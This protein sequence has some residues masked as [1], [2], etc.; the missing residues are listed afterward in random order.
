LSQG[1]ALGPELWNIFFDD[2][3]GIKLP[4]NSELQVFCDDTRVI[5][6]GDD[7]EQIGNIANKVL[8]KL[9]NW[10]KNN[11]I[12][13]NPNKT[14]AILFTNRRKFEKPKIHMNNV[15]I[16]IVD[17]IKYLGIIIDIKLLF[18]KHIEYIT[19]KCLRK[20]QKLSIIARNTWGLGSDSLKL[21][22]TSIIE[23][24]ILY[25]AEVWA[26][27]I[28]KTKI[29]CLRR[30]QRLI[31]IRITKAYRTISYESAVLI[32]GLIPIEMKI[33]EHINLSKIKTSNNEII[34]SLNTD[35]LERK[36]N[37]KLLPHQ[38]KRAIISV[39]NNYS[40]SGYRFKIFTD[41]SKDETKVGFAFTVFHDNQEIHFSRHRIGVLCSVF[42]SELLAIREALIWLNTIFQ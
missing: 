41:R 21:I 33:R 18:N 17:E 32:T 29:K 14:K 22:Y 5:I 2:I 37:H 40:D 10:G 28:N 16:D 24:T 9:Q 1:S 36:V 3:F 19:D 27:K 35:Y 39:K 26:E 20:I 4:K 11:G 15:R 13:F 31:C 30:I 8:E 12:Q 23:S 38:A 42:Q 6:T 34:E 25:G 7:I